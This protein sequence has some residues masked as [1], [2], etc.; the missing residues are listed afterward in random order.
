MEITK[1]KL[2]KV[3]KDLR[4]LNR[5]VDELEA[6]IKINEKY[7]TS[8][9][10]DKQWL[11]DAKLE[12]QI[13]ED[14]LKI[15]EDGI[16]EQTKDFLKKVEKVKTWHEKRKIKITGEWYEICKITNCTGKGN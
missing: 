6:T 1:T 2:E 12:K 10:T 13:L 3:R 7:N 5:R 14:I 8:T 4:Y 11:K 15:Y 9:L 16:E